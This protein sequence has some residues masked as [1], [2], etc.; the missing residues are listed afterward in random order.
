MTNT[1]TN[2]GTLKNVHKHFYRV[3]VAGATVLSELERGFWCEG[4]DRVLDHERN[5]WELSSGRGRDSAR[6]RW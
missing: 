5:P 3:Q 6:D 4:I 1:A 2:H